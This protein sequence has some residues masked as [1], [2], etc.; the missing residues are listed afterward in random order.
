M[1]LRFRKKIKILPGLSLNL[2]KSGI[3]TSI[4]AGAVSWNS[5][6]GKTSVNLPGCMSYQ[7]DS[8]KLKKSDLVIL[9]K[10]AGL[11]GY[12]KLNKSDLEVL[13]RQ[14]GII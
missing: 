14:E 3:S 8:N 5:R 6:T 9:A 12:S 13:L 2:S 11:K 1:G 4:K 7:T 10:Q